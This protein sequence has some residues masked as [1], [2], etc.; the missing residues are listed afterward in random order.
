MTCDAPC[1]HPQGKGA[2]PGA[3]GAQRRRHQRTAPRWADAGTMTG[4]RLACA[5]LIW[6]IRWWGRTTF[7]C[8]RHGSV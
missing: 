1:S 3:G 5:G 4:P 8:E 7:L 2:A 6:M